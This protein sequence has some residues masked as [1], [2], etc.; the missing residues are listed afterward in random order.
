MSWTGK[1]KNHILDELLTQILLQEC[2]ILITLDNKMGFFPLA[3][4]LQKFPSCGMTVQIVCLVAFGKSDKVLLATYF[5]FLPAN[6][7]EFL[8]MIRHTLKNKFFRL[9][10]S[11]CETTNSFNTWWLSRY[12]FGLIS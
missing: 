8:W 2:K 3:H 10:F 6:K 11:C 9:K 7:V 12:V 5:I 1:E 4:V